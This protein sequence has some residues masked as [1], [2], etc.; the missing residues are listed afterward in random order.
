MDGWVDGPEDGQVEDGWIGR[1]EDGRTSLR[2]PNTLN[3]K[4]FIINLYL[5]SSAL[6]R[7]LPT[8]NP[9]FDLL[10]SVYI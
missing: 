4:P 6:G 2:P 9:E 3:T 1:W 7:T 8:R 10:V 5:F